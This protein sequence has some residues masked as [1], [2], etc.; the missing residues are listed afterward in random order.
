M[1]ILHSIKKLLKLE[2]NI[3]S[4]KE[5]REKRRQYYIEFKKKN[6]NYQKERAIKLKA[7]NYERSLL[8]QTKAF[9]KRRGI[10]FTLLIKDIIIPDVCPLTETE[11]T[12]SVSEGRMLSNPYVYRI[13]ESIG[14]TKENIIITCV[15]AN[16]LRTCATKEQIVAFAKNIR[17]MYS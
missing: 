16:H 5:I 9:A 2:E 17:K 12:K 10:E 4:V 11:I 14:Y 1:F 6:P 8:Y 3:Q 7:V 13:D 15:L